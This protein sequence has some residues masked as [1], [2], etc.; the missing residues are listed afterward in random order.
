LSESTLLYIAI[1]FAVGVAIGG[2]RAHSGSSDAQTVGEAAL[3]RLLSAKF[4]P[5]DYHLMNHLTL[6]VDNGTTQI[7]HVLVSRFGI[8]VIESKHYKGWIFGDE[9]QPNWT[10]V[11]FNGKYKFQN[12]IHQN[13]RHVMAVRQLLD[14]LPPDHVKSAV[15]FTGDAE[16]KTDVP[17]G[18]FRA[19]EFVAHVRGQT[20]EVM[21]VNRMQFCVGRLET[22]RMALTGETDIEHV[23][24]LRRRHGGLG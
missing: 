6:R 8:F 12:P 15:V 11:L 16:F 7:D 20:V 10:Q 17:R 22:A 13:F 9:K 23:R 14:F 24:N 21:S 2:Y 5:P 19:E 1:A 4:I 3:S 18:V